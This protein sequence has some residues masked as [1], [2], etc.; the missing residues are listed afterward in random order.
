MYDRPCRVVAIV[1]GGPDSLCYLA[2]W[3]YRGCYAH[4][5]IFNYGQKGVKEVDI[6]FKLVKRLN[7]IATTRSWGRVLEH[8]LVDLSSLKELWRATQLVDEGVNVEEEYKP[9]VVVPLRNVVLLSIATAYAFTVKQATGLKTYVIYGAHYDDIEP[10]FDTWEPKYPDCSPECIEVL[11][12]AYNICHF[13]GER[14]VEIWS[15]SR[16]GLRKAD[17]MKKCYELIGDLIYETW[18]CYLSGEEHCGKCES[19]LNRAKAFK[20]AKI[21]DKTLYKSK[22]SI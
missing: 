14:S 8:K 20:E 10:R 3:L 4:V 1:S 19:C 17:N 12:A 5:L 16:E 15:P 18:S 11:Q 6:A 9:T 21:P 13:R 7:E 2:M 22:P